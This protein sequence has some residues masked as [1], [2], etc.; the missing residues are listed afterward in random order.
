MKSRPDLEAAF[1][2]EQE[3]VASLNAVIKSG[4]F[5]MGSGDTDLYQ[6]FAW[7]NWQLIGDGGRFGVVLPRGALSGSGLGAW[8]STI[9][10]EGSF[11]DVCFIENTGRWAFDMEPRYTVGL[12]GDRQGGRAR[13]PMVRAVLE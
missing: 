12:R 10:A 3:L 13:R 5:Q 11:A 7:R 8:R 6:A 2:E 4:P 9:L 1:A